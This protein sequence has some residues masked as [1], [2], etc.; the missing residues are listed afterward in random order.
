MS[1]NVGVVDG[2]TRKRENV[3]INE[4]ER[5]YSDFIKSVKEKE[6]KKSSRVKTLSD[7]VSNIYEAFHTSGF[8]DQVCCDPAK[9]DCS[10]FYHAKNISAISVCLAL[11]HGLEDPEG[12]NTALTGFSLSGAEIGKYDVK[13]FIA[14]LRLSAIIYDLQKIRLCCIPGLGS[15]DLGEQSANISLKLLE[16]LNCRS[17]F[18][19]HGI[20]KIIPKICTNLTNKAPAGMIGSLIQIG[21]VISSNQDYKGNETIGYLAL[22]IKRIQEY[23]GEADKLPMLHGGSTIVNSV[24]EKSREIIAGKT[25]DECIL[26]AGGGNLLAFLPSKENIRSFLKS[27]IEDCVKTQSSKGLQAAVVTGTAN[28]SEIGTKFGEVLRTIQH[29]LEEE[30]QTSHPEEILIPSS[31][32]HVCPFCNKR[33]RTK[34]GELDRCPV[35]EAKTKAYHANKDPSDDPTGLIS[36][37]LKEE[38]M[39]LTKPADITDLGDSIAVITIDGNMMGSLFFSSKTPAEYTYKSET[40]D[41]RFRETVRKTIE[42]FVK[43]DCR[44]YPVADPKQ[45]AKS[46]IRVKGKLGEIF[47]ALRPIYVGGDDLLLITSS[48]AAVPL[49]ES[50]IKNIADAFMRNKIPARDKTPATGIPVVTIS[51]GIAL[52]KEKF[53]IYFVIEQARHMEAQAKKAFRNGCLTDKTGTITMPSGSLALTAI[54]GAM[55]S[56]GGRSFIIRQFPPFQK[57]DDH[58]GDLEHLLDASLDD[59]YKRTLTD[60]ISCSD[61]KEDRLN[62]IKSTYASSGRRG[63]GG[64]P[65]LSPTQ[66]LELAHFLSKILSHE[67]TDILSAAKMVV[68]HIWHHDEGEKA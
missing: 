4:S 41:R 65:G 39:G 54:S 62:L 2:F 8:S 7:Q 19:T 59:R 51:A 18:E 47:I 43:S 12:I 14:L 55:P 36:G 5:V 40:F 48:R 66:Q 42:T 11:D 49:T 15:E 6:A 31:V 1:V 50:L 26:F 21:D 10:L 28:I 33:L 29:R 13:E 60:L 44:D 34:T 38:K 3:P 17:F 27:D 63:S 67:Y 56:E 22:D 30:K 20:N 32:H 9:P 57:G 24:L 25:C 52:A 37:L 35:C 68:P 61:R 53:P 46:R 64:H 23:I 58:I 45:F 16:D